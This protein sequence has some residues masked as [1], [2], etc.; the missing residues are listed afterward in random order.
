MSRG[1]RFSAFNVL[2]HANLN[3]P[4]PLLGARNF[5]VAT[6]GRRGRESGFPALTPLDERPREMQLMLRF[7][8]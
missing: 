6:F 3:N 1:F 4:E 5:G 2:N 8:F 7:E